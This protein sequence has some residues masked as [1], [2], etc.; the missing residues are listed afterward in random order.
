MKLTG[1]LLVLFLL[2]PVVVSHDCE[3]D[4]AMD[5]ALDLLCEKALN[6]YTTYNFKVFCPFAKYFCGM[7]VECEAKASDI[8]PRGLLLLK[9]IKGWLCDYE[10]DN[11][12][13]SAISRTLDNRGKCHSAPA[14]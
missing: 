1:I 3:L 4:A 14:M 7:T 5:G 2:V 13:V 10:G 8:M 6:W 11:E 9:G 12:I